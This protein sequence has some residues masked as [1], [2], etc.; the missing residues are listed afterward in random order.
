M[1]DILLSLAHLAKDALSSLMLMKSSY[2]R[3]F[4]EI[5]RKIN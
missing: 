4:N 2:K 3:T 5:V 1:N